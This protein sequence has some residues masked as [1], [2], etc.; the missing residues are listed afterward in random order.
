MIAFFSSRY[1]YVTLISWVKSCSNSFSCIDYI[2]YY[3]TFFRPLVIGI[4]SFVIRIITKKLVSKCDL[5][6]LVISILHDSAKDPRD[7]KEMS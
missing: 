1:E 4:T 5:S 2:D 3:G 7:V 6:Q